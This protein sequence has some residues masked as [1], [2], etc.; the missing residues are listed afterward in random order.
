MPIDITDVTRRVQY[1]GSGTGPYNFSFQILDD[2]DIAVYQD[3]T[4]LVKTTDYTVTINADGTGSITTT[5][6]IPGTDNITI[7]GA[8]PYARLTDFSTGGDFFADSV[9]DELDG[10]MILIQQLREVSSR[11][12]TMSSTTTFTGSLTFPPPGAGE[13]LRWNVAGT[14]LETVTASPDDNTFT[15]S[16]TGA[17]ARSWTAKVGESVTPADFGAIGNNSTN[18]QDAFDALEAAHKGAAIDLCGKTYLVTTRPDECNYYNGTFRVSTT[19]YPQPRTPLEHPLDGPVLAIAEGTGDH[20]WPGPVGQPTN[21][22]LLIGTYVRGWRHSVSLGSPLLAKISYDGGVTWEDTRNIYAE[23]NREPRGLVGG[24]VT[25]TRYGVFFLLIDSAGVAQGTRFAYTD[26]NGATW[27]TVSP[28]GTSFY[29]HGEFVIDDNG[30]LNVFGYGGSA[31]INIYRAKSTDDGATWTVTLAKAGASPITSPVEPTVVKVGTSKY[32]MFVRDDAGGN[33]RASTSTDLATW[34]DWADTGIANGTNPPLALIAMGRLWLYLCGRRSTAI[35]NWEDKLL[36]AELDPDEVYADGGAISG[37]TNLR[38]AMAG[39]TAMIGYLTVAQLRDGRY[40][41]YMVDGETVL[42][43]DYPQMSRIVRLGGHPPVMAAPA[44]LTTRRTRPPITHNPMFNHW[45]RGTSFTGISATTAVA[46]RW[47]AARTGTNID[48]T[49]VEVSDAIR[50][51]LPCRSRYAMRLVGDSSGSGRILMQ[52]FYGKDRIQPML[53]RVVTMNAIIGG[54]LPGYFIARTAL[55]FGS[56]GSSSQIVSAN[57]SQRS[58]VGDLTHITATLYT[59]NAD[60]ATWG[61]DPYLQFTFIS[62]DTGAAD[63]NIYA[64][65]FD[66]GDAYIPLDPMDYDEERVL[67]NQYCNKQTWGAFD[68]VGFGQGLGTATVPVHVNFPTKMVAQPS[69]SSPDAA[70]NLRIGGTALTSISYS[71]I[72]PQGAQLD[73]VMSSG[74]VT[75]GDVAVCSVVSGQEWSLIADVGY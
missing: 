37:T 70:S 58:I 47:Q 25:G 3:D 16:G 52:R 23:D 36:V 10:I 8:R 15:Q 19:T 7:I 38:V 60:G 74:T 32:L 42:G 2:D 34:T 57:A 13:Y 44:L 55:S 24:M 9:N 65:W 33:M 46:E 28:G 61:T 56:G 17:V 22:D 31:P 71:L 26:D 21:D 45:S 14:A 54:T 50:K 4:L 73:A 35:A 29:P 12:F 62:N 69:L 39:K 68:F 63:A 43:S 1:A 49:Q 6:S 51:A 59:P 72:S 48:I 40:V 30:D 53:D 64:L 20:F 41:G 27:T 66:Y 18:D 75:S 5:S 11:A 67:L